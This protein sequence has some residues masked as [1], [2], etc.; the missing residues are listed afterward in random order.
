MLGQIPY[1]CIIKFLDDMKNYK[2]LKVESD[3]KQLL[4]GSFR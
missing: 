2:E 3:L 4:I 1:L